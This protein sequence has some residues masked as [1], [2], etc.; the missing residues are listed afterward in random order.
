MRFPAAMSCP[1]CVCRAATRDV[2]T[3]SHVT[4]SRWR[5]ERFTSA[6]GRGTGLFIYGW[7]GREAAIITQCHGQAK[8]QSLILFKS[9]CGCR[10]ALVNRLARSS[11][12]L[13]N[14]FHCGYASG[15]PMHGTDCDVTTVSWDPEAHLNGNGCPANPHACPA[16]AR[17]GGSA[18]V[19]LA[20][21]VATGRSRSSPRG[22]ATVPHWVARAT[23]LIPHCRCRTMRRSSAYWG[24]W[25]MRRSI[26]CGHPQARPYTITTGGG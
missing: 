18:V 16:T 3:P 17:L 26:L 8:Q 6:G 24:R 21:P 1:R 4:V 10:V 11:R 25:A 15:M 13:D 12:I 20:V 22:S 9:G 19:A 7:P 23:G 14:R 5:R 2:C